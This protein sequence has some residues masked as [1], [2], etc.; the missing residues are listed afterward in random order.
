MLILYKKL[1]SR[2]EWLFNKLLEF[3]L[4]HNKESAERLA[5]RRGQPDAPRPDGKLIWLH[6]ASVGEAQSTLILIT[7]LS[8]QIPDAQF[9]VTSGTLT[10]AALMEKRLPENAFHQFYPLD[11]PNWTT[12]F[13]NHWKPDLILW[14]ESELWPN[15]LEAI[16]DRNIP[17]VLINARL[18][19]KSYNI[20]N[21]FS[22]SAKSLLST[23]QLILTQTKLDEERFKQLGAP[24]IVTTDNIKYSATPLPYDDIE[25]EKLH[26]SIAGRPT[27]VFASTHDGEELLACK[28]HASLVQKIPSLLTIIVPRHPERRDDIQK[29]CNLMKVLSVFRGG[30]KNLPQPD[31]DIYVADTL[32]ELGLFYK[33]TNIAVIGRSF[34]NDGGGGHNP[35]EAAQLGCAVLTGPNV[36]FQRQL[37]GE[38]FSIKAAQQL[39]DKTEL[40]KHLRALFENEDMRN[41]A[42]LKA[43]KFAESKANVI[44]IVMENL[45]PVLSNLKNGNSADAA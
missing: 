8:K 11:Y 40:L 44:N 12:N 38:M 45:T 31:T 32:G 1:T 20:W 37:F 4:K 41:N 19:N 7:T 21:I 13:L 28:I 2:C 24:N 14:M 25:L 39:N 35:I 15:M 34:S 42:I 22:G 33:L 9:L 16:K 5:E 29:L 26:T 10:S 43:S 17:A 30:G 36:Q 3:R 23:F 6:A 18:S 27:W